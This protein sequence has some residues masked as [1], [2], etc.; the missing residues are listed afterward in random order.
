MLCCDNTCSC[1]NQC[2][3]ALSLTMQLELPWL[4]RLCILVLRRGTGNPTF[5]TVV[6][7]AAADRKRRLTEN[8]LHV[9]HSLGWGKAVHP[10][11]LQCLQKLYLMSLPLAVTSCQ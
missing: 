6:P 4:C 11:H 10:L 1:A 8:F 9:H 2:L 5:H 3:M 7:Y